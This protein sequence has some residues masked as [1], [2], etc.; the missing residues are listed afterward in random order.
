MHVIPIP[1]G[2]DLKRQSN[3]LHSISTLVSTLVNHHCASRPT[4]TAPAKTD[5]MCM[6]PTLFAALV[7]EDEL[8][9]VVEDGVDEDVGEPDGEVPLVLLPGKLLSSLGRMFNESP[10]S[11]CP[12][13][14]Y[15][16]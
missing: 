10:V 15:T 8:P 2:L 13:T 5:A 14:P 6:S 12:S 9:E 4:A 16:V 7:L 1:P 11:S 3:V